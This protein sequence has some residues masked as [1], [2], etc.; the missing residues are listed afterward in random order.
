VTG[1]SV[2]YWDA[3]AIL[4]TLL[5][6]DHSDD[7]IAHA[8]RDGVHLLSSLAYTEVQAVLA[9]IER[10]RRLETMLVD[11]A[12]AALAG[13]PWRAVTIE[14]PWA[15]AAAFGKKWPLRGADLWHLCAAKALATSLPELRLV[16]YDARLL[17]AAAGEALVPA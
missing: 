1:R 4:S 16:S 12:R 11:A 2:L 13:G 10:E 17:S 7:A 5:A 15:M 8:R 14:P 3:S 6:D 9:R